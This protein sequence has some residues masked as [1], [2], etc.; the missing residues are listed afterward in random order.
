MSVAFITDRD[1]W[2]GSAPNGQ[3][4]LISCDVKLASFNSKL[5]LMNSTVS[6]QK[7]RSGH[8]L[9]YSVIK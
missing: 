4:E 1:E 5:I 2:V 9:I 8:I 7:E 6:Y 3:A